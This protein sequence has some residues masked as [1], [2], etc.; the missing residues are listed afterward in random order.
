[1]A[2]ELH[3]IIPGICGPLAETRS[4]SNAPVLKAWVNLLAKAQCSD[5]ASSFSGVTRTLFNLPLTG[6]FPSAALTLIAHDLYDAS[7]SYMHAD[8]VQLRAELDHAVLTP[9]SDLAIEEEESRELCSA[10]DQ[11]FSEAGLGFFQLNKNQW[12][13]SSKHR[14]NLETTPLVESIG[15]N[16]NFI[17]PTGQD[18]SR[19]K[20]VLTEAQMLMHM[21][22][23]NE[24]RE[25]DGLPGI[26]S[27]WFHGSGKAPVANAAIASVCSNEASYKGLSQILKCSYYTVPSAASDYQ[28]IL[29]DRNTGAVNVLHLSELESLTNYTDVTMWLH[30]LEVILN[31]WIYPLI[32]FA[33]K[34]R[35]KIILYTCNGKK[36][37]FARFD[38]L[39]FWCHGNIEQYVSCY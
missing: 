10:L 31:G 1:M 32:K 15:R 35:M 30:K 26:N 4:I 23:V 18:S 7:L 9:A 11:H 19:W 37:Q 29:L 36:Y 33:N 22:S 24:R 2:S 12:L 16:V 34:N 28:N 38:Q 20:Q 14:I 5:S 13:V 39:K 8:P 6:D 17:L 3:I 21:H 27:V 25:H